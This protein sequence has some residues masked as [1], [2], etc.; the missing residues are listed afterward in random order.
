MATLCCVKRLVY[1]SRITTFVWGG[2]V[3]YH[4]ITIITKITDLNNT[5]FQVIS[6]VSTGFT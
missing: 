1:K 4:F 2:K 6:L 3:N 5:L